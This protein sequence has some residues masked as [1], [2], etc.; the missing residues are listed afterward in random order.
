VSSRL[1]ERSCKSIKASGWWRRW[2]RRRRKRYE[3]RLLR[4]I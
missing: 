2:R 4:L 1:S 3:D